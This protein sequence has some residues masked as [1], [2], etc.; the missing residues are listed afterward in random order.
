MPLEL[1]L[2]NDI[3][4]FKLKGD[5]D[6]DNAALL[7]ER[8]E[9]YPHKDKLKN[10]YI[11]FKEIRFI[12][13]YGLG[14]LIHFYKKYCANRIKIAL[15]NMNPVQLRLIRNIKLDKLFKIEI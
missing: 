6:Q 10:I 9:P 5:L 2:K 4:I 13:S 8:F 1:H 15:I 11:D 7:K 14:I 12:T 3:L